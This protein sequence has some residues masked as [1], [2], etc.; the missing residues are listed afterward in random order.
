MSACGVSYR[1]KESLRHLGHALA[2]ALA[3]HLPQL[4]A[5]L[6]HFL[7]PGLFGAPV[8]R[9]DAQGALPAGPPRDPDTNP[10]AALS[11]ATP[12][13]NQ[14]QPASTPSHHADLPQ[15]PALQLQL[16]GS[17]GS[18]YGSSSATCPCPGPSGGTHS[19]GGAGEESQAV[20][21][22]A[23]VGA[24]MR[25]EERLA[26]AAAPQKACGVSAAAAET[27]PGSDPKGSRSYSPGKAASSCSTEAD[28][29]MEKGVDEALGKGLRSEGSRAGWIGGEGEARPAG[30]PTLDLTRNPLWL[31]FRDPQIEGAFQ[32]AARAKRLKVGCCFLDA[33]GCIYGDPWGKYNKCGGLLEYHLRIQ[34]SGIKF[35][36]CSSSVDLRGKYKKCGGLLE[37]YF[38]HSNIKF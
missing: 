4:L 16:C 25:P 8:H 12:K 36:S 38:Q 9:G 32:G 24:K 29:G 30:R 22:A 19:E 2:P 23:Q 10:S 17:C 7:L 14:A 13:P 34:L 31:T 15:T 33:T 11:E 37:Y 3:P 1:M 26:D 35:L 27:G 6:D 18:A 21:G 20:L 5:S 28:V